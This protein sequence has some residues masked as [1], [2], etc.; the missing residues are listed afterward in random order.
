MKNAYTQAGVNI[1]T[2]AKFASF[3]KH[4]KKETGI[5]ALTLDGANLSIPSNQDF[6][7][8]LDL[9]FIKTYR[10]PLLIS[11]TDGVGTKAHLAQLFD[12][13]SSIGIDLV[14]M[15]SNDILC[16]GAKTLQFLDYIA[17]SKLDLETMK[18]VVRSILEGCRQASCILVGGET[19]EHPK[20]TSKIEYDLAGFAAGVVERDALVDGSKIQAGDAIIALPSSGVH[21]NGI[22]LIRKLYL[23]DFEHLPDSS[24]DRDFLLN[25]I[26]KVP[27]YIYDPVLRP[28]LKHKDYRLHGI[29]HITGGAFYENI[30]RILT[31]GLG[32]VLELSASEI[33]SLFLQIADRAKVDLDEMCH[34]YNMGLGMLVFVAEEQKT[35]ILE[36]LQQS[37][38]KTFPEAKAKP[39]MVGE[40]R[41][42][43][44]E[45]NNLEL[46]FT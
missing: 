25:S 6:A 18:K 1:E 42:L 27:T 14:A 40:I 3:I 43:K 31:K 38:A 8:V 35:Q 29:V 32:A 46:V 2:G 11:S 41:A 28:I 15:C 4:E 45:Q 16:T 24:S 20:N 12:Y 13:H 33:P 21:A 36:E 26:L 7:S 5:A 10:Y 17:C 19:A 44:D 22:S 37:F 23:K 30:P 34:I 39:R 9:S